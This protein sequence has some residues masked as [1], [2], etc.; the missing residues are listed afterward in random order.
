MNVKNQ[1]KMQKDYRKDTGS[2][3]ALPFVV[4]RH[5]FTRSASLYINLFLNFF[6]VFF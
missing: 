4:S 1:W 6:N 3:V 5:V 2:N